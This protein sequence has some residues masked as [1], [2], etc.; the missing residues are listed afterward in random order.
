M[1]IGAHVSIAGGVS[2]A[3]ERAEGFRAKSL[4]IFTKS[5]RGWFGAPLADEERNAFRHHARR[6]GLPT[7]AHG[8]YLANLATEDVRLRAKSIECVGDELSRC[9]RLG[10]P[11]LVIH[12]GGHSDERR[13]LGLIAAALDDIHVQT[14]GFRA[15]IALE[16]TAG[17]GNS[18]GW[19][20]E[21]IA[22]ILALARRGDRLGVCLDTCHL[23]AAG[24]DIS[25]PKGY[26]R[27]MTQLD[28]LIGLKRVTSF[29]LNDCKKPLGCRVD[30]HEEIGKGMLGLAPFRCLVRDA[31]FRACVGVLE[32]PFP[33]RY[34]KA[35]RLLESL[36]G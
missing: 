2:R 16:V 21:H 19:R 31:R 23:F 7:I 36:A 29:H 9:E 34:G 22:E 4:Q 26:E 15:R 14:T 25:T 12:P 17:Q 5:A 33:E 32:T 8:S 3:F 1:L 20:F 27:V 24:Y 13:G 35:I 11:Y 18:L 30:R 10:I 28:R 6:T